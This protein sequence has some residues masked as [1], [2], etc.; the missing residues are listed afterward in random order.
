MS[1]N[2]NILKKIKNGMMLS[3]DTATLLITKSEFENLNFSEE[4][5][6]KFHLAS[7]KFCLR[8]K[9]QSL[10]INEKIKDFSRLDS[11]NL[12]HVLNEEQKNNISKIFDNK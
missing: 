11:E 1:D 3:C 6:L 5:R 10:E 2:N 9:E 8:F 4:M 7:C 12:S